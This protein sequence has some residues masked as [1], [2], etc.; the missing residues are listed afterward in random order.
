M[1]QL[2]TEAPFD[3]LHGKIGKKSKIIFRRKNFYGKGYTPL[4]HGPLEAYVVENPRD[5]KK[6]PP[7]PAEQAA[8]DRFRK[9]CNDAT[10]QLADPEKR[11]YWEERF[12]NQYKHPEP[13]YKSNF[14][15]G[16]ERVFTNLHLFVRTM[17]LRQ[18]TIEAK[19]QK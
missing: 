4:Y 10:A 19:A 7:S 11:A 9:A 14:R 15:V 2:T 12:K 5:R 18:Y 13:G 6:N 8:I 3:A 16:R 1:A 17:L